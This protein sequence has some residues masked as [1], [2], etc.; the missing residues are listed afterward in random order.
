M[1]GKSLT[2]R[3]FSVILGVICILSISFSTIGNFP[4]LTQSAHANPILTV[5]FDKDHR[6]GDYDNVRGTNLEECL[7]ICASDPNCQAYTYNPQGIG[8]DGYPVCWLKDQA[9]SL[10]NISPD[11]HAAT[12][13]VLER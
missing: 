2:N 11:I 4:L 8:R 10:I 7:Q 9:N 5:N 6:G 1:S 13:E 12:G 3:F